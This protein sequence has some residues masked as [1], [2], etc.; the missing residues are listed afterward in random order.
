MVELRVPPPSLLPY[1]ANVNLTARLS[2]LAV[3]KI[4]YCIH[5]QLTV[6]TVVTVVTEVTVVKVVTVVRASRHL[7]GQMPLIDMKTMLDENRRRFTFY[8]KPMSSNFIIPVQIAHDRKTK[9]S[10]LTWNDVRRIL[11]Y[12]RLH[13]LEQR[14][15]ILSKFLLRMRRSGYSARTRAEVIQ[16]SNLRYQKKREAR[17][18]DTYL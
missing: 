8:E 5:I 9:L 16:S 11:N 1:S 4:C 7:D 13:Y 14:Q 15:I 2:A 6:L 18:Q 12:D 17:R 3:R 10:V